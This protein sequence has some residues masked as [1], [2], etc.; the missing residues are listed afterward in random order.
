MEVASPNPTTSGSSCGAGLR[1]QAA[2]TIV[3][4][5]HLVEET[6]LYLARHKC[7]EQVE[8]IKEDQWRTGEVNMF[9]LL[10]VHYDYFK[11]GGRAKPLDEEP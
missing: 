2:A 6:E 11:S 5:A 8:A 10:K 4:A 1:G 3:D 7:D 9:K